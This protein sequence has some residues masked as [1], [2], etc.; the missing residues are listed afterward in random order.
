MFH[1]YLHLFA[2]DIFLGYAFDLENLQLTHKTY[3]L[4][5]CMPFRYFPCCQI[6][7][8]FTILTLGPLSFL[9]PATCCNRL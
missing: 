8:S 7:S 3:A 5:R 6:P 9:E 2:I 1:Y 4:I